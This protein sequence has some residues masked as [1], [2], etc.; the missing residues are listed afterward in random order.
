[1]KK[2]YMLTVLLLCIAIGVE[3]QDK[4]SK[5]YPIKKD[6]FF[7]HTIYSNDPS[8]GGVEQGKV[9]YKVT[10]VGTNWAL[11]TVKV[12]AMGFS[13]PEMLQRITC[14]DNGV[15]IRSMQPGSS[16]GSETTGANNFYLPN[17]LSVR[18]SLDDVEM[19]LSSNGG[20]AMSRIMKNRLVVGTSES[21]T[22]PA[23]TFPSCY[24]ITFTTKMGPY[25]THSEQ[26]MAEGKGVIKTI[27]KD[28]LLEMK[29][30]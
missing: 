7:T 4:C 18:A 2:F 6:A 30:F 29:T 23:G 9:T 24:K 22:T 1:M 10:E 3:A 14:T 16:Q 17:D 12:E 5:Y 21:I 26:W 25:V 11:Y 8:V 28:T 13:R 27:E 20:Y 19:K 15:S